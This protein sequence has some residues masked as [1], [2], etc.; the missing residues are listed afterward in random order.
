MTRS[1]TAITTSCRG[2]IASRN[3]SATRSAAPES[4]NPHN[5]APVP[6]GFVLGR[7][8]YAGPMPHARPARAGI[9]KP[10]PSWSLSRPIL[11]PESGHSLTKTEPL[12]ALSSSSTAHAARAGMIADA[13]TVTRDNSPSRVLLRIRIR[14]FQIDCW[15]G[16][17]RGQ[18]AGGNVHCTPSNRAKSRSKLITVAPCSIARAARCASVVRL[19]AVPADLSNLPSI[20]A[21]CSLG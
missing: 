11:D 6:R 4:S 19:P 2:Q 18:S 7:F 21:C 14:Q 13:I 16:R 10:S 3:H 12:S 17:C 8:P 20:A 9:R 5:V 15:S 1:R